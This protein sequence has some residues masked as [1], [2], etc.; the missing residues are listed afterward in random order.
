MYPKILTGATG[1]LGSHLLH[2]LVSSPSD[3][4]KKVV[5]LVRGSDDAVALDRVK[6][7][8]DHRKLEYDSRRF[9]VLAARLG[10]A[11]LGL[12]EEAYL[13]LTRDAD[14]IIHVSEA[15]VKVLRFRHL[16]VLDSYRRPLGLCT[17]VAG[18]SRLKRIIFKASRLSSPCGNRH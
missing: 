2:Q 13:S 10:K 7:A 8:L 12:G 3:R 1:S 17:S 18:W 5:C 4:V 15:R 16:P 14:V 11:D 6:R 9:D